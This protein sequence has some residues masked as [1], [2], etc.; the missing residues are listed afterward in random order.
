MGPHAW[1]SMVVKKAHAAGA[2]T[3]GGCRSRSHHARALP[4]TDSDHAVA[5]RAFEA[6]M[7]MGKSTSPKSRRHGAVDAWRA[8]RDSARQG[9]IDLSSANW[10]GRPA[11]LHE[12]R[13]I[14]NC[15]PI[16][17]NAYRPG[18]CRG[19]PTPGAHN[20]TLKACRQA[21]R[22]NC[23]PRCWR[24]FLAQACQRSGHRPRLSLR[25][26][27]WQWSGSDWCRTPCVAP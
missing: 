21:D 11:Q 7:E 18:V 5:K 23:Q 8:E 20:H 22:A 4:V 9:E 19:L 27:S 24:S 13:P 14:A 1:A 2:R 15:V 12:G 16:C 10:P 17:G 3:S 26:A 25:A 6:L